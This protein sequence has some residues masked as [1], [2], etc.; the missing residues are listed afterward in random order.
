M[1]QQPNDNGGPA[2]GPF[3]WV[4]VGPAKSLVAT[5]RLHTCIKGRYVS[6]LR[7]KGRL[8]CMDSVCFHAGGPLVGESHAEQ[9]QLEGSVWHA[10]A[11]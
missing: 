6:I 11:T 8:T 2:A 9:S 4:S 1:S 10:P 5:G 7:V 3:E